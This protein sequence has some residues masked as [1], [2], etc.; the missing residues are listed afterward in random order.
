ML[1]PRPPPLPEIGVDNAVTLGLL[2]VG[3]PHPSGFLWSVHERCTSYDQIKKDNGASLSLVDFAVEDAFAHGLL[4]VEVH[5]IL[6][7]Q[8]KRQ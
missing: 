4:E 2:E 6:V 1:L 8:Q 7:V 5:V 3:T